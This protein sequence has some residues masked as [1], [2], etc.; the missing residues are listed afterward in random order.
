VEV[1]VFSTAPFK[2]GPQG[3]VFDSEGPDFRY[4]QGLLDP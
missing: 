2:T 1:R 4:G 3:P